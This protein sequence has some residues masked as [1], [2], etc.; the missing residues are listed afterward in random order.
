MSKYTP[1]FENDL[2]TT[3]SQQIRWIILGFFVVT[4]IVI[5]PLLRR[6]V[7]KSAQL[8]NTPYGPERENGK[9]D[10]NWVDN[11]MPFFVNELHR[12]LTAVYNIQDD[13]SARCNVYRQLL[14][15]TPNQLIAVANEYKNKQ[16]K[17][18][19]QHIG[20]TRYSGCKWT[21][22]AFGSTPE[23][24]LLEKLNQLQIT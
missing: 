10:K 21:D 20:E 5:V 24:V 15:L 22:I 14:N 8:P 16:C 13:A 1:R 7:C 3:A 11:Q 12:Q 17:T 18:M 9:I 23:S 6:V 2:V 19:R 4:I